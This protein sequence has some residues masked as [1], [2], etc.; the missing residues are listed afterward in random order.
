MR[1]LFRLS[2]F[3]DTNVEG[4]R[5]V[6]QC[7]LPKRWAEG[8]KNW[9]PP[10]IGEQQREPEHPVSPKA[11]HINIFSARFASLLN[12]EYAIMFFLAGKI[13][14]WLKVKK[15]NANFVKIATRF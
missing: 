15:C 5:V 8:I 14:K 9:A 12:N 4:C 11:L 10:W 1:P 3:G 6:L 7:R 2:A 13:L